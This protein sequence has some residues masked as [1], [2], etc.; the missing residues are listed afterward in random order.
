MSEGRRDISK[1]S[2]ARQRQIRRQ[3]L[4]AKKRRRRKKRI[5][6]DSVL[7][8]MLVIVI[9]IIYGIGKL[10]SYIF[11]GNSDDSEA[12]HSVEV[13]SEVVTHAPVD[14]SN[15]TEEY[16]D[17][18]NQISA[19]ESEFKDVTKLYD[20]FEN[21]PTNVLQLVVNNPET[22]SF[23][24]DYLTKSNISVVVN[25]D[26]YYTPGEIPHFLQ[27]DEQWGYTQYGDNMM[28]VNGC[29]P[30]CLS[31]IVVGLTGNTNY[32]PANVAKLS[33]ESGY[34]SET[35]TSWQ[36][37]TDGA[38]K[39]GVTSNKI[40]LNAEVIKSELNSG[41][42]II[43]SMLPGDFTK[44]GHFIVITGIDEN[45]KLIVNDPNSKIRTKKH[46]EIDNIISQTKSMWSYTV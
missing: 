3:R 22:A 6:R 41:H 19:F 23:A 40:D 5:I 20:D 2:D 37:M 14:T 29:G 31:M 4:E 15:F 1:Y 11:G 35:G 25:I 32:N 21:Y 16:L 24:A 27:W 33:E 28:A 8:G 13:A 42:P 46:W 17:F 12:K 7:A 18:Y 39:M 9:L 26:S 10:F 34:Y 38:A 30:T 45:G 44:V 43:A 36:M